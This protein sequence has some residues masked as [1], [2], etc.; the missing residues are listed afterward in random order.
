MLHGRLRKDQGR[1][2]PQRHV[3]CGIACGA[4]LKWRPQFY[5]SYGRAVCNVRNTVH[6]DSISTQ[7]GIR[8]W[9]STRRDAHPPPTAGA[10]PPIHRSTVRCKTISRPSSPS[11][12]TTGRT[13]ASRRTPSGSYV[14]TW[15]AVFWPMASPGRVARSAATTSWSPSPA[16]AAPSAPRA[17]LDGWPRQRPISSITSY[18]RCRCARA[19]PVPT[20]AAALLRPT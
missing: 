9:P 12:T 13:S 1:D 15:S 3:Q 7:A 20:E 5:F 19:G 11:V 17:T 8:T 10:V 18:P 14:P 4:R 16:K 2:A 6:N